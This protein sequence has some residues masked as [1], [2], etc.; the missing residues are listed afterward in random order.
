MNSY[1]LKI[2]QASDDIVLKQFYKCRDD[3]RNF[4]DDDFFTR[5]YN[6]IL[7]VLIDRGYS[8]KELIN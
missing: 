8:E 3:V 4:P 2:M 1:Y 6:F 7:S 5:D